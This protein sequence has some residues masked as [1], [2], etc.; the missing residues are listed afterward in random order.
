MP[1]YGS[2]LLG[3]SNLIA[4]IALAFCAHVL[5]S[6]A[7]IEDRVAEQQGIIGKLVQWQADKDRECDD[8]LHWLR[9]IDTKMDQQIG[10]LG[11]I[12]GYHE[13]EG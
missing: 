5:R 4:T 7:K 2:V 12:L 13:K 3:L 11:K 10:T 9:G 6:I 1:W 8:R